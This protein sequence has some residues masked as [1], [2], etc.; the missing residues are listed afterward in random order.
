MTNS[1]RRR[2]VTARRVQ[3]IARELSLVDIYVL[4][5]VH[6]HPFL[7]PDHLRILL[8]SSLEGG[9]AY[10]S[11]SRAAINRRLA[12]LRQAGLVVGYRPPVARGT[13]PY[14]Y[15]LD[16]LGAHVVAQRGGL[17]RS[18]LRW[19]VDRVRGRLLTYQHQAEVNEFFLMLL[20]H[21]SQVGHTGLWEW[22]GE[23]QCLTEFPWRGR[24]VRIAPDG[25]GVYVV[26]DQAYCFFV[27]WDRGLGP[28]RALRDKAER[29]VWYYQSGAYQERYPTCPDL[30][31]VTRTEIRRRQIASLLRGLLDRHATCPQFLVTYGALIAPDLGGAVWW[32]PAR[33][34]WVTFMG[35]T[36]AELSPQ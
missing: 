21:G 8:T 18:E 2:Y 13:A 26:D 3:E 7:T 17:A 14:H 4:V 6:R 28:V 16:E 27:E 31:I 32:D 24:T 25:F 15:Y 5:Q 19:S 11:C 29:Y 12:R 35:Q 36:A 20:Q 22:Q 33:K 1:K 10:P 30:W 34:Q 23:D 9:P